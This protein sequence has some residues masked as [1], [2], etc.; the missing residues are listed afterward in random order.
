VD[1][2]AKVIGVPAQGGVVIGCIESETKLFVEPEMDSSFRVNRSHDLMN[3]LFPFS[4]FVNDAI[5]IIVKT[6]PE[7]RFINPV[8][9]PEGSNA[10][11]RGDSSRIFCTDAEGQACQ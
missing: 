3:L 7:R 5:P 6:V 11:K 4:G 9:T 8:V 10:H 1:A 2:V